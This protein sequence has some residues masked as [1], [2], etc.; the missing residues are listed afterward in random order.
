MDRAAYLLQQGSWGARMGDVTLFD[1]MLYDDL[2][3]AF[4]D[5]HSS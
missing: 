1:S 5:K 2:N 4:S 3:D